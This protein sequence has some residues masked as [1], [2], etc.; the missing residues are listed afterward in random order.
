MD[1]RV[2]FMTQIP[3]AQAVF[4]DRDGVLNRTFAC[5]GHSRPPATIEELEIL[6]GVPE[7]CTELRS[8]G[9]RLIVVSNQP[10]IRRGTQ[11][12]EIVE[13]INRA[14]QVKLQLDDVRICPHDDADGCSCRKPAP[15]L[16]LAAA[17]D[18][19]IALERSVMVGDR[20]RDV[21]SGRRAGC[22]TVFVDHGYAERRPERPDL[23]V[24]SLQEAVPWIL[25][26]LF[27]EELKR[28]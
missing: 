26:T 25:N 8:A 24:D 20:W 22:R 17:R 5:E 16:L 2:A 13:A 10:D 3:N 12:P 18:W 11:R 7:A 23:I 6:P 4:L 14:I 1:E 27:P 21:E 28:L 15:G 19:G 9:L